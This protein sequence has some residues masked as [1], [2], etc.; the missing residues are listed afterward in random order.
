MG[1]L[2]QSHPHFLHEYMSFPKTEKEIIK[3]RAS[4][5]QL[6]TILAAVLE[7]VTPGM[8]TWD[9]DVLAEKLIRTVGGDPVFRGYD[10][11]ASRSFPASVCTSLNEEVVHGIPSKKKIIKRGDLLKVDIGI[12]Y[13][14]MV[15]DMART[16]GV[17]PIS[18]EAERLLAVTRESLRRGVAVLK[19]GLA[20]VEYGRTVQEYVESQGF[21]VI[22]DLVG[23]GTGHEL[24][25][26]PH[27]PNY[28][29]PKTTALV[30]KG[31]VLALEPMVNIGAYAVKT[32]PDGWTVITA[33]GSLGAHF[34]DTV[35]ITDRGAEVITQI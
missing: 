21:S 20:L 27:V 15:T 12:R 24:H 31:M 30:Q 1:K 3:L 16:I 17:G 23:H 35:V 9:I 13:Q 6:A 10:V 28:V 5:R 19:P 14:G 26:E 33:D 29:S 18:E 7:K 32:A 25:E 11:G 34:E 8:T 2:W 22:R 4:G